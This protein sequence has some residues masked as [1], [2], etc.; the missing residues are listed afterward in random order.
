MFIHYK[1]LKYYFLEIYGLN[2]VE[3]NLNG[4]FKPKFNPIATAVSLKKNQLI[5][6]DSLAK[7]K[8]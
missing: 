4:Y 5:F 3:D 1:N 7:K 2:H 8:D 6:W